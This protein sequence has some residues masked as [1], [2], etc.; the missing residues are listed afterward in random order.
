MAKGIFLRFDKKIYRNQ[1]PTILFSPGLPF[2]APA[3]ICP[4]SWAAFIKRSVGQ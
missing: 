3:A 1:I 2:L 4:K